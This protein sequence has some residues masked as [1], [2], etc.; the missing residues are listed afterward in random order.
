M[1]GKIFILSILISNI[2]SKKLFN[3]IENNQQII[4][5]ESTNSTVKVKCFYLSGLSNVYNLIDLKYPILG[6]DDYETKSNNT[7][8]YF[9]FCGNVNFQYCNESKGQVI[10]MTNDECKVEAGPIEEGNEWKEMIENVNENNINEAGVIIKLNAG[11]KCDNTTR[12]MTFKMHCDNNKDKYKEEYKKFNIK[13][14]HFNESSCENEIIFESYYA[15]PLLDFYL[16]WRKL[17]E[18]RILTTIIFVVVGIFLLFFGLKFQKINIFILT[19]L[20]SI[21]ILFVLILQ[22]MIPSGG[23]REIFFWLTLVI[24]IILGV[25]I[26]YIFVDNLQTLLA[27]ILGILG[28]YIS[29]SLI[30]S[31]FLSQ[32][33]W[34]PKIIYI[35]SLGVCMLGIF[36]LTYCL[37]IHI[38]IFVTAI[39]G[40]YLIMRAC[41]FWFGHY[42]EESRLIDL[43]TNGE[44]N[45]FNEIMNTSFL[46]YIIIWGVLVIGGIIFQYK[47]FSHEKIIENKK[48]KTGDDALTFIN[49][50]NEQKNNNI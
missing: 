31:F 36:F 48:E 38:M 21:I 34:H 16:I 15:C 22:Y 25:L 50:S 42:P 5:S 45:A 9:N 44:N 32:I 6:E 47:M 49:D 40:S 14:V 19:L 33:T 41:T 37:L 10:S 13:E 23:N 11:E 27:I 17:Q 24:S 39:I 29:G 26:S 12:K 43:I 7:T 4:L 18:M 28:G 3:G 2:L 1:L 46:I 8:I 35:L 30:Y 20:T